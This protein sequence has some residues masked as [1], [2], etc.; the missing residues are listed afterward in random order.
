[1]FSG[2][3]NTWTFRKVCSL[4]AVP[5]QLRCS[6]LQFRTE[7]QWEVIK[8]KEKILLQRLYLELPGSR[9][10]GGK[11]CFL[12]K[13]FLSCSWKTFS[14]SKM[15][16]SHTKSGTQEARITRALLAALR[17]QTG[18]VSA[19]FKPRH[20]TSDTIDDADDDEPREEKGYA[21]N[22]FL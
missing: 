13:D 4:S 14:L 8:K 19:D 2:L 20:L 9:Q 15:A 10:V 12:I 21:V 5:A 7:L 3:W 6:G 18:G 11:L 1:M 17:V 22:V 16:N